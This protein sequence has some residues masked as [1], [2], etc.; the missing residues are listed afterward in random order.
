MI[1]EELSCEKKGWDQPHIKGQNKA[2]AK[3]EGGK[4]L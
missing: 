3:K 1:P 4:K 2:L